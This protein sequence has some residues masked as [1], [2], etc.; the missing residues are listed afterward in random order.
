VRKALNSMKA[1][2]ALENILNMFTHTK[3]NHE[4]VQIL[5][6]QKVV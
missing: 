4:V 5:K 6:K 1:D 2:E 3:S